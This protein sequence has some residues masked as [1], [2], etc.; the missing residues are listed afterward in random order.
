MPE[1]SNPPVSIILPTY[2]RAKFLPEASAT[3]HSVTNQYTTA[4]G[5]FNQITRGQ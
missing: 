2:N 5:S 3:R 1:S 4:L